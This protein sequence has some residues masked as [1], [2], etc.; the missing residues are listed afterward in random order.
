M[1][2]RRDLSQEVSRFRAAQNACLP[3]QMAAW[4]GSRWTLPDPYD[5]LELVDD[6]QKLG[7]DVVVRW[8]QGGKIRIQHRASPDSLA[9]KIR[10]SRDWF[11]I[12]G[13]ITTDSGMVIGLRELLNHVLNTPGG[14]V[15]VGESEY[16]ALTDRFRQRIVELGGLVESRGKGLQFHSS[17]SYAMAGLVEEVGE[18][19]ATPKW[20]ERVRQFRDAQALDPQIPSTLQADLRD[21]Q[22]EGFRWA[23]RLAAWGAGACLA[24]DM[25][26][27]KTLQAL[28]VAL[29]RAEAGPTLVI[30]PTSVCSNW[31]TEARRFTPTLAPMHF[32]FGD[33]EAMIAGLGPYD[34]MACS[35]ALMLQEIERIE[36]V[37]WSTIVLDEAQA[38]KNRMT[39]RSQAAMR[40]KGSFRM[41]TTGTPIENHLGELW[42]LIQ[43]INPGLLGSITSFTRRFAAPIHG[44]RD[45]EATQR[46]KRLIRPFVLRR[47]KSAVLE[48]LPPRTEVT[49]RVE[50]SEQESAFYEA[51]R[52]HA[53]D[54]IENDD[55]EAGKRHL[56]IL[57]ELTRLRRACCHPSL[58]AKDLGIAGSK[59][60]SFGRTVGD[61]L[62]NGHKA[63]VFSQFVDHLS[64][65]RKYLDGQG[66]PYR[67]LDGRTPARKRQQEVDAIPGRQRRS[68]PHQ[69]QGGRAGPEPHGRR[70][71]HPHGPVV[72]PRSG[73]P[74]LG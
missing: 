37:E 4:D 7:D 9:L 34:L 14:Y 35:Y 46:L 26:L 45:T 55:S 59:L 11:A 39:K 58:V 42:N 8:P 56:L 22:Q 1:R 44:G 5:C 72:E 67:Y 23:A 50:M 24:D 18:L 60:K 49:I 19:D 36:K 10:K 52:Q 6:L 61:L 29:A 2:T 68:L 3:L 28:T 25:G 53:V 16:V 64:I 65:V 62:E 38:I 27:G 20:S 12:D 17:R 47:T 66:I 31:I 15:K 43:F 32:G 74:G 70:L 57:A 40:L 51:L 48:Q 13:Q 69:P 21:Y 41:I 54:R 73:G 63:L 71:R 30:A 33:R